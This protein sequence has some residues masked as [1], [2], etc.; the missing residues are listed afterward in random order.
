MNRK[1]VGQLSGEN[2][3]KI[4]IIK[5]SDEVIALC[6]VNAVLGTKGVAGF[7]PVF[8]DN[9]SKNFFG[10]DPPFKGIKI[11]QGDDGI[12]ADLYV[13]VDYG[14][15]IPSVAWDIQENVKKE[16]QTMIDAPVKAINIHVQGVRMKGEEGPLNEQN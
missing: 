11:S 3:E 4:G 16:I 13:I 15:K 9:F 10:K 6:I 14:V 7:S 12:S 2:S 5:I 8:S 1:V